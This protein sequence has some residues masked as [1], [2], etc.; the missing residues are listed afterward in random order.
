MKRRQGYKAISLKPG[1]ASLDP[2]I[3]GG[4]FRRG[5]L[6]IRYDREAF[7]FVHHLLNARVCHR[8][9]ESSSSYPGRFPQGSLSYGVG[10]AALAWL[11]YALSVPS[12]PTDVVT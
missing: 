3:L 5:T 11:E 12:V 1:H 2:T 10:I 7:L 8:S 9:S 6:S 4:V